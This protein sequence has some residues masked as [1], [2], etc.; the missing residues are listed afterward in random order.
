MGI[1]AK[2]LLLASLP[3]ILGLGAGWG[4]ALSQESCGQMVGLLFAGKCRGTLLEYQILLQTGGTAL[5]CLLVALIGVRGELRRRR[6]VPRANPE[7]GGTS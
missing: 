7:L 1:L 4:F 2:H 5:G 6:D 3:L